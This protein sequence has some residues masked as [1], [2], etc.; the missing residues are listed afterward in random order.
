MCFK[1]QRYTLLSSGSDVHTGTYTL[2]IKV[3]PRERAGGFWHGDDELKINFS[4]P[5]TQE[6]SK[7]MNAGVMNT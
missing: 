4:I 6:G 2:R 5:P 1:G 3:S 7:R